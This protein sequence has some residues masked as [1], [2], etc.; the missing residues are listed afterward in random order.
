MTSLYA[1]LVPTFRK[2]TKR[3]LAAKARA[4]LVKASQHRAMGNSYSADVYA[5]QAAYIV[6]EL[7]ARIYQD[8]L[9]ALVTAFPKRI[10]WGV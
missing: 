5:S 4:A 2:A 10:S 6:K 1:S 3:Q 8:R 7:H 9:S